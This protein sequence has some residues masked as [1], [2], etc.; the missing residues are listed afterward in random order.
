MDLSLTKWLFD[1]MGDRKFMLCYNGILSHELI[2]SL[3]SIA[4]KKLDK[5]ETDRLTKK[6]VFNVMIECLQTIYKTDRASESRSFF[7][8]GKSQSTYE[9]FSCLYVDEKEL[10]SL[11]DVLEKVN[12]L[13]ENDLRNYHKELLLENDKLNSGDILFSFID[14]AMKSRNK[15]EYNFEKV[16]DGHFL[17]LKTSIQHTTIYA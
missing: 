6:K 12:A 16:L 15:I 11:V 17:I 8:L 2:H 10:G 5:E 7:M 4:E 3:L 13:N 1:K 14:I 9:L